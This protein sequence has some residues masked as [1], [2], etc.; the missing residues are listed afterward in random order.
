MMEKS[1]K[2]QPLFGP[3]DQVVNTLEMESTWVKGEIK[4]CEKSISRLKGDIDMLTKRKEMIDESMKIVRDSEKKRKGAEGGPLV[5][6]SGK[7]GDDKPA[8]T[9]KG[10]KS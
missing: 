1:M 9:K 10:K 3:V 6:S 8:G 5:P 2:D 7:A 4:K